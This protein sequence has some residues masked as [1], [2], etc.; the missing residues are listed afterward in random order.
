MN[1][2]YNTLTIIMMNTRIHSRLAMAN[3]RTDALIVKQTAVPHRVVR[4]NVRKK[5]KNLATSTWK[6]KSKIRIDFMTIDSLVMITITR[7]TRYSV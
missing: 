5:M 7:P 3:T 6:P 1:T 2:R 4:N